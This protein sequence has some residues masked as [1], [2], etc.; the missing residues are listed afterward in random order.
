MLSARTEPN[1]RN[2]TP[3]ASKPEAQ[4]SNQKWN[5]DGMNSRRRR[6]IAWRPTRGRM[7]RCDNRRREHDGRHAC[8]RA[9]TRNEQFAKIVMGLPR[10]HVQPTGIARTIALMG[11]G[12][13]VAGTLA[14]RID[15]LRIHHGIA[16]IFMRLARMR[17]QPAHAQHR[18]ESKRPYPRH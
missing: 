3:E 8:K 13:C 11:T 4:E 12:S 17:H 1:A 9:R 2:I 10:R 16:A 7:W 18:R 15:A 6:G 14:C 5:G